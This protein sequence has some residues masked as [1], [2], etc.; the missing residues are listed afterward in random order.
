[1]MNK[2]TRMLKKGALT[3]SLLDN[4]HI[5][6]VN[7]Q[8]LQINQ[9]RGNEIFGSVSDIFLRFRKE[10]LAYSFFDYVKEYAVGD[11]FQH[12][13][14]QIRNID[15]EIIL[16][17]ASENLWFYQVS[18]NG[19]TEDLDV[20]Y[21][22]DVGLGDKN[23]VQA[24]EL[25]LSQYL[26]HRILKNSDSSIVCSRQNLGTPNPLLAQGALDIRI[27]NYCTDQ[28]QWL[29]QNYKIN[30]EPVLLNQDLPNINYQFELATVALQTERF[31]LNGKK[32][33]AFYGYVIRHQD[34]PVTEAF[35]LQDIVRQYQ[36]FNQ[37]THNHNFEQNTRLLSK[38]ISI[39]PLVCRDFAL[40]EL[41]KIFGD[42][43]FLEKK[44]N[45][46][47]SFFTKDYAHVVLLEKERELERPTGHIITSL[48]SLNELDKDLLTSTNYSYGLFNAQVSAGN[49]S[50][51][52]FLSANRGLLNTGRVTGQRIYVKIDECYQILGVPSAYE[53]GLNYAKWYYALPNDLIEVCVFM[54]GKQNKI[55]MTISSKHGLK[56]DYLLSHQIVMGEHEYINSYQLS[57]QKSDMLFK[58]ASDS[59]QYSRYPELTYKIHLLNPNFTVHDDSIFYDDQQKRDSS[60][61]I[62]KFTGETLIKLTIQGTIE[63]KSFDDGE[64]ANF[65]SEKVVY[66]KYYQQLLNGLHFEDSKHDFSHRLNIT[67]LWFAH[68]AMVHYAVPHGLE[69][70]GGAAWGTRDV[71]QGPMEFFLATG[72]Y[73]LARDTLLKIFSYEHED[74]GEWPQWFFFDRYGF[75]SDGCHGDIVFWPLK[76][77]ADYLSQTSD[78]SL[79][80]E[81]V[82]FFK[83]EKVA[84]IEQHVACSLKA[85]EKRL[86]RP[87]DLISY[88]G[89]DWDDT[90]QPASK[91]METRFVSTW[92]QALAYQTL[93]RLKLALYSHSPL[94][95][96]VSELEK[97]I[98]EGYQKHCFRGGVLAGFIEIE[99]DG[100]L[101][102]LLHPVDDV[103]KIHY[104][105][106]PMTRSIIGEL[107]SPQEAQM[108]DQIIDNHLSFMDGIRL[109]DRPAEYNG[110][111]SQHFIR[112]EQASNVGREIS[113]LYMHAQ[114]RYI[115]A[116]AKLGNAD[117][118][119][120]ALLQVM[121]L[122]LVS[123]VPNAALRQANAYFSSSDGYFFDRY[124][125][126]NEFIRLKDGTVAAR[127][128][129][130][131]YSSGPGIFLS[132]LITKVLGLRFTENAFVIDPVI[133][134]QFDGQI[135]SLRIKGQLFTIT[136]HVE[137]T[138]HHKIEIYHDGKLLSGE[139]ES[140]SYRGT[141]LKISYDYLKQKSANLDVYLK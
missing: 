69:Q 63:S 134:Q 17:L 20:V 51:N 4:H 140:N 2:H 13:L 5:E 19:K 114:I 29:G 88:A 11:N 90:L 95:A 82:Q 52:K 6:E 102:Y 53:M 115:E 76:A 65:E 85:I 81:K 56:Y 46:L 113:L 47:L 111:V 127:G 135:V 62:V 16:T 99:D 58:C 1:M 70:V 128:G 139:K 18:L 109:M 79:L 67:S 116:M 33:F 131:I 72:N 34:Q 37:T 123:T 119:T 30:G 9:F 124:Q 83:Q 71:A 110:G 105:L 28:M 100:S 108:F 75:A 141:G 22:Q 54:S 10:N 133:S 97:R 43:L 24:N 32:Q 104:R 86:I 15:F 50:M 61:V 103:T 42:R 137:K 84:S 98:A 41:D 74:G 49:T 122:D 112:A 66:H 68:N 48:N 40:N 8:N 57:V 132:T 93:N 27:T 38:N 92:T 21:V 39:T 94:F 77:L 87:F 126:Q 80:E 107:S 36:I 89:G 55:N 118:V 3:F 12:L 120:H 59:F 7:F 23:G 31:S 64:L 136:Y 25:Y 138:P 44:D 73:A 14:G 26:D 106:I 60:L 130:R 121:P 129:W 91:K 125:Y 35:F 78:F 96:K 101:R 117:K 45:R